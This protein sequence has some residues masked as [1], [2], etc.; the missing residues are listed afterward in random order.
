MSSTS[1]VFCKTTLV[2]TTSHKYNCNC[3][4]C[5]RLS[6]AF[7]MPF[8]AF[9]REYVEFVGDKQLRRIRTSDVAERLFCGG[10]GAQVGMDY[11][12]AIEPDTLW[13]CLGLEQYSTPILASFTAG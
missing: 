8:A 9:P 5:R 2:T 13:L 6:G 7:N 11:G 10:C 12:E 3:S 1:V 4:I